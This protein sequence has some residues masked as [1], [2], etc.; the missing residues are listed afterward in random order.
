VST[1]VRHAVLHVDGTVTIADGPLGLDE[2][3]AAVGGWI[4]VVAARGPQAPAGLNLI[5]NDEGLLEGLP[6]NDVASALYYP[7]EWPAQVKHGIRGNVLAV[8]VDAGGDTA[9]ITDAD[10]AAIE[11]LAGRV[12]S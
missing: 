1:L 10:V 6:L 3:K 2:C 5:V 9:S 12:A 11:A 4:D 8:R 7:A